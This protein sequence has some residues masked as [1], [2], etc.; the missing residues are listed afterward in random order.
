MIKNKK[1]VRYI[2]R[3]SNISLIYI[4]K[5]IFCSLNNKDILNDDLY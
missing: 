5:E 1:L 2:S 3:F 4:E